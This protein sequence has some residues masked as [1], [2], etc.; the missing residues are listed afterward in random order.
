M[1]DTVSKEQRRKNMQAI[2]SRSKLEDKVTKELW[3]RGIRF[4]KNVKKLY[5]SP[6][7][8]I[9][10]YKIVIFIDS[11]FWHACEKH[12]NIPKSNTEYWE[13]KLERNKK[14]D[15]EVNK[16][17][18]EKDWNIKRIW[19]HE[20]KEDFNET[21]NRIVTFIEVVKHEPKRKRSGQ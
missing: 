8:V 2:K 15:K 19:E 11:C 16:Y 12:G 13:K 5:G 21:I 9:Q 7:I 17:Y 10:K 18:E 4:R 6:D 14:R 3:H 1:T 20:I